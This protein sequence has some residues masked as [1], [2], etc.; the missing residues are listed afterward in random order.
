MSGGTPEQALF[1]VAYKATHIRTYE[2]LQEIVVPLIGKS[3]VRRRLREAGFNIPAFNERE[4]DFE[5]EENE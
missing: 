3:S 1:A 4:Y 5:G 2:R